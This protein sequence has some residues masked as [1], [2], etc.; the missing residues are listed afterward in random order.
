MVNS[1]FTI[2]WS[3]IVTGHEA[4]QCR[5]SVV[6]FEV[7]QCPLNIKLGSLLYM[8]FVGW[9]WPAEIA[10]IA[11]SRSR[12]LLFSIRQ[13]LLMVVRACFR[14]GNSKKLLGALCEIWISHCTRNAE[15]KC[16]KSSRWLSD[17][18]FISVSHDSQRPLLSSSNIQ[19]DKR[20]G[21]MPKHCSR[22]GLVVRGEF[23]SN[24]CLFTLFCLK[25]A[26]STFTLWNSQDHVNMC[27]LSYQNTSFLI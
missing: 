25:R 21:W 19:S 27:C 12:V 26:Y 5:G 18:S 1:S 14:R 23:K 8:A 22:V 20:G 2:V 24:S 10:G 4:M 9:F 16:G 6:C 11:R 7:L 3:D 13:V 15:R 17:A